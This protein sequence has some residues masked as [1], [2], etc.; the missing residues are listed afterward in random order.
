[1]AAEVNKH[2]YRCCIVE[3][4]RGGATVGILRKRRCLS[5][6]TDRSG[7]AATQANSFYDPLREPN[8]KESDRR[9]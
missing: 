3:G 1:M 7:K 8:L 6:C 4:P 9:A 5:W 2:A